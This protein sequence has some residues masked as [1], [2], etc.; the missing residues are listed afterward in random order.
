M[1]RLSRLLRVQKLGHERRVLLVVVTVGS[2]RDMD[3]TWLDMGLICGISLNLVDSSPMPVLG[4]VTIPFPC[5]A[6]QF[7]WSHGRLMDGL[8]IQHYS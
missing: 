1:L 3:L 8:V 7:P 6:Q 4:A 2:C 5:A